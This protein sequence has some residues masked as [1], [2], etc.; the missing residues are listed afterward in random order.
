MVTLSTNELYTRARR[1]DCHSVKA[2]ASKV[3]AAL[4]SV[5]AKAAAAK[6]KATVAAK[7]AAANI[8]EAAFC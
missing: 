3:K 5:T 2:A 7:A 1:G 4:T 8:I 6:V